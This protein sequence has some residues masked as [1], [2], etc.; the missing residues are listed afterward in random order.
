MCSKSEHRRF[1]PSVRRTVGD[2]C[3]SR[4]EL[5]PAGTSWSGSRRGLPLTLIHFVRRILLTGFPR[6]LG[7][8]SSPRRECPV[9]RR[10]WPET[11]EPSG[12]RDAQHT[13]PISQCPTQA[14]RSKF[15][16]LQGN[17]TTHAT[18]IGDLDDRTLLDAATRLATDERRAI[19]GLLR[20]L[21]EIDRRRLYLGEGC[22][23]MFSY[24]T[25]VLHLAEGAAYNRI[26]A[27][28]AA[29]SYPVILEL[30]EQSAITLTAV[31]LLAPHLTMDN[32]AAV[33]ASA[34][35]KSKRQIEELVSSLR[36]Q[37]DAPVVVRRL[38]ASPVMPVASLVATT[39]VRAEHPVGVES[40]SVATMKCTG[41]P[42]IP[43]ARIAAI[44]PARLPDSAHRLPRDA[45]QVPAR[46]GAA[47]PRGAVGR[48]GRDLR[49]GPRA[50]GRAAR[51]S[52]LCRDRATSDGE[53]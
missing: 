41:L 12:G 50:P 25:Q 6:A 43:P 31:R 44:A 28:W 26:E 29:R 36:P 8:D 42:A 22:A 2:K 51:T 27:A 11:C 53:S 45:R 16:V 5:G 23:S 9:H 4:N 33:L 13:R 14:G 46:P 32:H 17:M 39:A 34:T 48:R 1:E 19:A 30:F 7:R 3:A 40:R 18:V 24:C 35:H 49:S 52:A 10:R 20:V 38:P 47:A 21:M 15:G 37:P